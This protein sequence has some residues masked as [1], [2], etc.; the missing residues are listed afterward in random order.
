MRK[1][2]HYLIPVC[3]VAVAVRAIMGKFLGMRILTSPIV[4]KIPYG[5]NE[6]CDVW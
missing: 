5:R 4:L 3:L 2:G 1:I 6:P